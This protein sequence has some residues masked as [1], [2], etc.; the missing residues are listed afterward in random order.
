[1]FSRFCTKNL[2]FFLCK[3]CKTKG[4]VIADV[5]L[6]KKTPRRDMLQQGTWKG[7]LGV[8]IKNGIGESGILK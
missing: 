8:D 1:V 6:K 2:K 7:L 4:S 5:D 3:I